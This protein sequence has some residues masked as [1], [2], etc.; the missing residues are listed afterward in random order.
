MRLLV[1]FNVCCVL[2]LF[3]LCE[4]CCWSMVL[5]VVCRLFLVSGVVANVLFVACCLLL[6]VCCLVF[7][8]CR[9]ACRMLCCLL[10]LIVV[11]VCCL[12]RVVTCLLFELSFV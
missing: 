5:L 8:V 1:S 10:V 2:S 7:V 4:V 12:L 9:V 11:V 3:W 6:V